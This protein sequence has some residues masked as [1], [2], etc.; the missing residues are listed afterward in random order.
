MYQTKNKLQ[1]RLVDFTMIALGCAFYAF[2]LVKVN[3][4]NSLAE[5]GITGIT[6]IIRYWLHIDPAYST[7]IINVPLIIIAL[8]YLGKN[9]LVYTVHGTIS[10]SF[11]IWLWQRVPVTINISHDMFIAGLLAGF[12]GGVG[13]GLIYRFG[14][15]TGGTDIVARI[16][17]KKRG[18]AMGKTLL[19]L[20][21][22]VLG[23]S[24][25][26]IS[27]R[28][29]MYTLLASYVFSRIISFT[30]EGAYA[31]RGVIIFSSAYPEITQ[32]II[33][34][35]GRGVS[36]IQ[37][38]GAFSKEKGQAIYCVVSPSELTS[39][40]RIVE[41]IDERAFVSVL[42]V[43]EAIGEGFTYAQPQKSFF[44]RRL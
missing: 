24:L 20:D 33:N 15:T 3:I 14:G 41:S 37:T 38:T 5:G 29:M 13:S 9:A 30:Q 44:R 28:Q 40:K 6:L 18:V 26:Y 43:N 31:A 32:Q 22:V 21:C 42:T 11:F 16:F 23:L 35:L 34:R 10:L 4:A 39:L 17:E 36:H 8:R 7:L 27:I 25:S 2:G 12:F 19:A 1:M